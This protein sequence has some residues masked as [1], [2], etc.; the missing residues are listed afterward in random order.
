MSTTHEPRRTL[1]H[2]T[3]S[4]AAPD[5]N[6]TIMHPDSAH[7]VTSDSRTAVMEAVPW[8]RGWDQTEHVA[9]KVA[10]NRWAEPVLGSSPGV[11]WP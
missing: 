4:V 5:L 3:P 2:S 9:S 1:D 10:L 11:A 7:A 6:E 8:A